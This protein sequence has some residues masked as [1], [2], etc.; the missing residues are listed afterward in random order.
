MPASHSTLPWGWWQVA[1]VPSAAGPAGWFAPVVKFR[2]L[3]QEPQAAVDGGV[4]P[5]PA[6]AAAGGRRV[7]AGRAEA[8]VLRVGDR[9][10]GRV[11]PL[12]QGMEE[13]LAVEVRVRPRHVVRVVAEHAGLDVD[14]VAAV[15]R[16]RVVALVAA[17]GR[18]RAEARPGRGRGREGVPVG[19]PGR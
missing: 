12:V 4:Y 7:V 3:W 14:V 16:E 18:H 17:G 13:D 15:L 9:A 5:L 11:L 2:S 1:H 6:A 19:G 8:D 10:D